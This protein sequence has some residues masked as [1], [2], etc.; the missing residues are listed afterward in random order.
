M[1][2]TK[3]MTHGEQALLRELVQKWLTRARGP[4]T[5]DKDQRA[6]LQAK[7]CADE[8][9]ALLSLAATT[10]AGEAEQVIRNLRYWLALAETRFAAKR[11]VGV[12]LNNDEQQT[13]HEA[14]AALEANP[15]PRHSQPVAPVV[16]DGVAENLKLLDS[17]RCE[18]FTAGD[19]ATHDRDKHSPWLAER[20]CA[21]CLAREIIDLLR[22]PPHPAQPQPNSLLKLPFH[23]LE[24]C[25]AYESGFGQPHRKL[26]NPYREGSDAWHAYA[27]GKE[28]AEE[29]T[30][31]PQPSSEQECE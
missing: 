2:R 6:R 30:A 8:L 29:R 16:A 3:A 21:T 18:N 25:T 23:V 9:E 24:I 31:Q 14:R 1:Q 10:Q 19:C 13:L 28:T 15:L 11:S 12:E 4:F 22:T 27:H 5:D 17:G 7:D 26:R 20:W